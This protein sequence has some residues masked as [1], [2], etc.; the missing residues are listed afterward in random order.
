MFLASAFSW[1]W[2]QDFRSAAY[3]PRN[4]QPLCSTSQRRKYSQWTTCQPCWITNFSRGI[5]PLAVRS[6]LTELVRLQTQTG[7]DPFCCVLI[8]RAL[9]NYRAV[10]GKF[11][12]NVKVSMATGKKKKK[13]SKDSVLVSINF[14]S[15]DKLYTPTVFKLCA[16]KS[17]PKIPF[18]K[19]SKI[20]P[21]EIISYHTPAQLYRCLGLFEHQKWSLVWQSGAGD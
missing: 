19:M 17:L 18:E 4:R 14:L 5:N 1:M 2:E 3:L 13:S 9:R 7:T 15:Q 16:M 21:Q 8:I 20:L 6:D 11:V 12:A 10:P